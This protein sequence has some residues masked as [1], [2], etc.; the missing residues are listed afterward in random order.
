MIGRLI[1]RLLHRLIRGLVRARWVLLAL[2]GLAVSAGAV[3]AFQLGQTPSV[4]LS[5]P[6]G[7]A[8]PSTK[9]APES[10]EN[11][12]K[13][14]QT[15]SAEL[16]WSGL[17][18]EA[19]ERYRVRGKNMQDDQRQLDQARQQGTKVEQINYVGGQSLPDGTSLQFYVVAVRGPMTR[20]DLEYVTYIFTL[21]RSGKIS[22]VQ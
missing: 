1:K 11:Y 16:M 8:L 4:S 14:Q 17:S 20:S 21:D 2:L 12:L 13:G 19:L 15:Y 5:L 3:A 7:L 6:T 10:T 18:D 9:R 22:K